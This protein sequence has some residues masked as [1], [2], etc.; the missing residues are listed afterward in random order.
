MS[1]LGRNL[2]LLCSFQP[3][4]AE[5][6]RRLGINRQQFNKYLNGSAAPSRRN[7]RTI[8]DFF[9]VTE[10]EI[11]LEPS[12][13]ADLISIK[14]VNNKDCILGPAKAAVT[15]LFNM[16]ESM[17]RYE[18]FYYRYFPSYGTPGKF[19]K[20]LGCIKRVGKNFYWKN[21]ET[22]RRDDGEING[23]F[24]KWHGVFLSFADRLYLVEFDTATTASPISSSV[25]YPCHR[26]R[27]D[28]LIGVQTGA[29]LRRGR[30]PAVSRVVLEYLGKEID[31]RACIAKCG[32][33]T[34]GNPELDGRVLVMLDGENNRGVYF[35]EADEL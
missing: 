32:L 9:G 20:S 12:E 23:G 10:S 5:V 16:S 24:G 21:N 4:I 17:D 7:L 25:F 13:F 28:Y 27:L 19:V 2:A 29:P 15:A 14:N 30:R 3:S 34:P 11:I 1:D 8:C 6:C 35:L 18:G 33:L 26:S 31:I 22:L